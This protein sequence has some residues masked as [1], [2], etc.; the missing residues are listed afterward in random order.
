MIEACV[1]RLSHTPA[2]ADATLPSFGR[3]LYEVLKDILR[4]DDERVADL[5]VAEAL[6]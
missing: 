5:L 4:Y 1:T 6:S 2:R 3:D